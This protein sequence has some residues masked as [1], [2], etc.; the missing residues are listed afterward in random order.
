MQVFEVRASFT[1]PNDATQYTSGDLVA[2]NTT[3]GSVT[4][5]TFNIPYGRGVKIW[6]VEIQRS[7]T[8]VTNA[9]FRLHLYRDSPTVTNG[10]NGAWL[11]IMAG[12]LGYVDVDG[13]LQ[14]FS[15]DSNASGVYVNNSVFAPWF[16]LTDVDRKL[17]G[18]L[19][20]RD[21]Y[22][23]LANEVFT[24]VLSGESYV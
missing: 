14:T 7:D 2:N 17:Y 10:D 20:A 3:A 19:E 21:T 11:S 18:L 8:D 6:R 23:P 12:Y 16:I 13:T 24:V 5:M 9:K 22:T 15:D 1:R 4:P